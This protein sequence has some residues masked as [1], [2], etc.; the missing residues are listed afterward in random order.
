MLKGDLNE[1]EKK[2]VMNDLTL[3][4]YLYGYGYDL[5]LCVEN[6]KKTYDWRRTYKPENLRL[7]DLKLAEKMMCYQAGK[8]K[9]GYPI[10]YIVLKNDDCPNDEKGIAEKFKLLVYNFER[11]T[12]MMKEPEVHG[13]INIVELEGGYLSLSIAQTLKG[14]F[15]ELGIYY[16]ERS[17]KIYVLN[18][19]WGLSFI[20]SF[21]KSFL[22]Q[23]VIDK[24]IFLSG[25]DI[26]KELS[27]FID[28]KDLIFYGKKELK[29]DLKEEER[30][31]KEI[32]G[33]K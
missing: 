15:D 17:H 10:H 30:I 14:M 23:H 33:D 20:W 18:A 1:E 5:K 22:P 12:R 24:Y 11:C 8:T 13:L 9:D 26:K 31:E 2:D 25:D 19:G 6:L 28:E 16:T 27:K 4:R 7:K 29:W 32:Y 21:V 3:W